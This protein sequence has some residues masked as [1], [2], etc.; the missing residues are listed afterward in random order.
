MRLV[1]RAALM[2]IVLTRTGICPAGNYSLEKPRIFPGGYADEIGRA[3]F[4]IWRDRTPYWHRS[5][6]QR[7]PTMR[8]RESAGQSVI[9][10]IDAMHFQ[11]W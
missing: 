3:T 2:V 6:R 5:V 4:L 7:E 11:G 8:T 9:P 10:S 1:P